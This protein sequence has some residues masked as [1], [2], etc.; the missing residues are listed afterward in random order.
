MSRGRGRGAGQLGGRRCHFINS[1]AKY[2]GIS[3]RSP[4]LSFAGGPGKT[5]SWSRRGAPGAQEPHLQNSS[6]SSLLFYNLALFCLPVPNFGNF[7]FFLFF[8]LLNYPAKIYLKKKQ[9]PHLL[10]FPSQLSYSP[11]E[12]KSL[13]DPRPSDGRSTC[14]ASEPPTALSLRAPVPGPARGRERSRGHGGDGGPA[15]LG[16]P[17]PPRGPQRAAPGRSPP[18]HRPLL[19]GRGAVPSARGGGC[20]F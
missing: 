14:G 9:T 16:E 2:L 20:T 8:S 3:S 15:S 10:T 4:L 7:F 5:Q 17:S 1:G 19:H 18:G 11:T 13:N 6:Q 12:N